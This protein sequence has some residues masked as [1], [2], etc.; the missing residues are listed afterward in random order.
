[1]SGDPFVPGFN[2]PPFDLNAKR[3]GWQGAAGVDYRLAAS[4]WHLSADFRY[5]ANP[6]NSGGG[7][8]TAVF[9]PAAAATPA[10]VSTNAA[11]R[12]ENAWEADF[13][14]GRD[15]ESVALRN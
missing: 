15:L 1:M 6:S 7:P 2:A 13:M 11:N 5:M 8:E 3:W 9:T 14:V 10:V 4:P 12:K